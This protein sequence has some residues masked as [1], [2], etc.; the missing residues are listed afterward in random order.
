[1]VKLNMAIN[2]SVAVA[3]PMCGRKHER[4]IRDGVIFDG[5]KTEN[6][7][8]EICPPKSA[9]SKEPRAVKMKAYERNGVV[10]KGSEDLAPDPARDARM[11]ELWIEYHGAGQG[12]G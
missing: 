1:M 5:T 6:Y 7:K 3:C 11:A 9:C 10:I 12:D 4:T 2:Y 8:E